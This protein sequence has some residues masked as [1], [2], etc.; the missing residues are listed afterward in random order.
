MLD[1][2]REAASLVRNKNRKDLDK[3]R[4][5]TLALVHLLEITG[6]AA[7]SVSE[8]TRGKYSEVPW[9][10]IVSLRNQLIHGYDRVDLDI[11]W[12]ILQ[13]D[14]PPLISALEDILG[15]EIS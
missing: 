1:H 7:R 8:D 5:L 12:Q 2:V 14:I 6:E 10:Q 13:R 15:S 9:S 3:E 11:L 4:T